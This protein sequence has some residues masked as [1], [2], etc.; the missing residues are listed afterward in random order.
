M[1]A[2]HPGPPRSTA[3]QARVEKMLEERILS[4]A[5]NALIGVTVVTT[6]SKPAAG[7]APDPDRHA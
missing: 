3:E 5:F 2:H 6:S 7:H 4:V 1:T